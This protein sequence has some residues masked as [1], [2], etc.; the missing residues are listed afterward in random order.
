MRISVS[1]WATTGE[2]VDQSAAAVL[3]VA[4]SVMAGTR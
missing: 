2:D 4:A 3:R 1:G